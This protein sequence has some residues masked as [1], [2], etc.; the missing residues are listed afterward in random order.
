MKTVPPEY[1]ATFV[2]VD[3]SM[4]HLLTIVGPLVGTTLATYIGLSGALAVGA[5]LRFLGFVLFLVGRGR[6]AAERDA[7]RDTGR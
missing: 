3:K 5:G 7:G 1:S 6:G 4:L 2:A